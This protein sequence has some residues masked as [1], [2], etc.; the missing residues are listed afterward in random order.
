MDEDVTN[1]SDHIAILRRRWKLLVLG[2]LL[3]VAVALGL[4]SVQTPMYTAESTLLLEPDKTTT[5]P[6]IMDPDEV[7]TQASVVGSVGVAQRV[8]DELKL[9][10]TTEQLLKSVAVA[11]IEQTRTVSITA[12]RGSAA[13]AADV[14]NAFARQYIA[15]RSDTYD[16]STVNTRSGLLEKLAVVKAQLESVRQDLTS[17]PT[18]RERLDLE[19]EEVALVGQQADSRSRSRS[20]GPKGRQLPVDSYCSRHR[21]PRTRPNPGPCGPPRSEAS[22]G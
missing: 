1:L 4:S 22:S 8:V 17:A 5:S 2:L 14:A 11:V 7:S 16:S 3:G 18:E 6:T 9:E 19:G 10:E 21:L 20:S 13:E 12:V 15:F